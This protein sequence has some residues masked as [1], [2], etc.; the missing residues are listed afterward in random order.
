MLIDLVVSLAFAMALVLDT[1]DGHLA[2]LQ[3]SASP[4]GRW[5]DQVLDEWADMILHAAIAWATF[6]ASGRPVWLLVGLTY[7][8]GKYLF[9]FQSTA[10]EALDSAIRESEITEPTPR[11]IEAGRGSFAKDVV[12]LPGHADVRWH[13][14]I[15]LALVGRLDIALVLYAA[16]FPL[17][18][19]GG[20][21]RKAVRHVF[22]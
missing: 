21:F 11:I 19:L 8:M 18:A 1:A 15:V 6:Q 12:R 9:Q 4:F 14:W 20:G 17:R 2:R 22:V 3:G 10:G 16:Y 5:L 7:A 13:L